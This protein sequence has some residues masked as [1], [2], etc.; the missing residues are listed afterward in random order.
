MRLAVK[1]KEINLKFKKVRKSS[2]CNKVQKSSKSSRSTLNHKCYRK[3]LR[4]LNIVTMLNCMQYT[5][6][7]IKVSIVWRCLCDPVCSC[8]ETIPGLWQTD[9]R[10]DGQTDGQT[11][12]HTDRHTTRRVVISDK[13]PLVVLNTTAVRR[14]TSIMTTTRL[15]KVIRT[16]LHDELASLRV[17][18][19]QRCDVI[20]AV[21]LLLSYYM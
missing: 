4:K 5:I 19:A 8:L 9:R 2:R 10:T 12:R 1:F 6:F 3:T 16:M 20:I 17:V 15:H 18:Q 7:G 11:D 21:Y 14:K 13:C